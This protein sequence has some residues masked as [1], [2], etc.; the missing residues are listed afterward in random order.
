MPSDIAAHLGIQVKRMVFQ[1]RGWKFDASVA[2]QMSRPHYTTAG[3]EIVSMALRLA[4]TFQEFRNVVSNLTMLGHVSGRL[5]LFNRLS[6]IDPMCKH[7]YF[8]DDAPGGGER[9]PR[10]LRQL[11]SSLGNNCAHKQNLSWAQRERNDRS[12]GSTRE[13]REPGR[14]GTPP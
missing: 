8:A 4:R 12:Y 3:P 9:N 6:P 1:N 7:V 11:L 14:V 5:A 10:L 2:R 13:K